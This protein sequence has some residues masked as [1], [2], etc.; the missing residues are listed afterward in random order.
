M[1]LELREFDNFP[2][3]LQLSADAADLK[4]FSSEQVAVESLTLELAV[5]HSDEEY[6]CSGEI[7]AESS[8]ECCRCLKSYAQSLSAR[9]DF[10]IRSGESELTD[11]GEVIKDDEDYVYFKGTDLRV[12]INEPVRQAI[13]LALPMHPLCSDGCKGLCTKCGKNLSSGPCGCKIVKIDPRWD[14]LKTIS[15]SR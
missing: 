4:G 2:V 3:H 14:N 13:I 8:I 11:S 10:I 5:Q 6:F 9:T 15:D 12:E 7:A 1:I